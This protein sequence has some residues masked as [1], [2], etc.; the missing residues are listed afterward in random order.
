MRA[1]DNREPEK[2]GE[3][4]ITVLVNRD[5]SL[6]EITNG[7]FDVIDAPISENLNIGLSVAVVGASDA[8]IIEDGDVSFSYLNIIQ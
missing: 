7:I 3:G 6:P 2:T 4:I 8:D 5:D 1:S